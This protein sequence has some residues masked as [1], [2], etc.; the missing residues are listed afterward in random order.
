MAIPSCVT[1]RVF[2]TF[3]DNCIIHTSGVERIHAYPEALV[4]V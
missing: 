2:A 4:E 3:C 1:D